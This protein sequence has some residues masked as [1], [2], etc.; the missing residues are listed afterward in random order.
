MDDESRP[1]LLTSI[2]NKTHGKNLDKKCLDQSVMNL[3]FLTTLHVAKNHSNGHILSVNEQS[4]CDITFSLLNRTNYNFLSAKEKMMAL[5]LLKQ[6]CRIAIFHGHRII[7]FETRVI[8]N[9]LS[10]Y[11]RQNK[12]RKSKYVGEVAAKTK[13]HSHRFIV[14]LAWLLESN[15]VADTCRPDGLHND[16]YPW[17]FPRQMWVESPR[18]A[19]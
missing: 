4:E 11:Q 2:S 17:S 8:Y 3:G 5:C 19:E 12:L 18:I 7:V 16:P 14:T 6:E 15:F 9:Q 13:A 10:N 1:W